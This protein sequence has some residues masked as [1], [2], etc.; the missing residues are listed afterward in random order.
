MNQQSFTGCLAQ[1]CMVNEEDKYFPRKYSSTL[2][3]EEINS[4]T[5]FELIRFSD[6]ISLYGLMIPINI[7]LNDIY[8]FEL[9]IG[10]NT[11]T[12]ISFDLLLQLS[13][14][15]E[16]DDK[17]YIKFNDNIFKFFTHIKTKEQY[18][19]DGIPLLALQYHTVELILTSK[20]NFK[21]ELIKC[22]KYLDSNERQFLAQ[23][24]QEIFINNFHV[25]HEL[26][27]KIKITSEHISTGLFIQT[28]DELINFNMQF[29]KH[30]RFIMDKNMIKIYCKLINM[31]NSWTNKHS[32]MI[33][34][35][36]QQKL[37]EE[38]CCMLL[39]ECKQISIKKYLYWIPF[40]P[41]KNWFDDIK[42]NELSGHINFGRNSNPN[43]N[44]FGSVN[45]KTKH[46]I[47]DIK[48]YTLEKRLL[49]IMCGMAGFAFN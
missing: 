24:G 8:D 19:V 40:E 49:R 23:T 11:I 46:D 9:K 31:S 35:C 13:I 3:Y 1:L 21:Y 20:N 33:L 22:N 32:N 4:N 26:S 28:T 5:N 15:S 17:Y 44:L 48:V 27:N 10:G 12:K 30:D 34:K 43:I 39:H 41:N 36:M 42:E 37:P 29:D 6:I 18:T 45:V 38:I 7:N 2:C 25:D 16:L 14:I 47:Y